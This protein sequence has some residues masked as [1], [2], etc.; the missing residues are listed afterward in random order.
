MFMYRTLPKKIPVCLIGCWLLCL[1]SAQAQQVRTVS[2]YVKDAETGED[3][4][5]ASLYVPALKQGVSTNAYG[6]FSLTL[7]ADSA[8]LLITYVG[9]QPAQRRLLLTQN[10]QITVKLTPEK[11]ELAEVVVRAE[12]LREKLNATQMSVEKLSIREIKLVP[13]L[14]GEVDLIKV[15]QLK[16]GVQSGGEGATGLYVRG[17]GADQ[18]LVLLD[19]ATVYN[20]SHLFGFFSIFNPDAVKGV[21]LYK[22]DFPARY[23]GRLSSVVDVKLKDG[24]DQQFSGSGGVGIIA[25]R[26][27]LE[28][29]L[30]KGKASYMLSG[31]RTY[32]DIFTRQI[33][34]AN[35]GKPDYD[36]IPDY[37]FYDLNA[38]VNL[39][40][41]K[42]DR[43][44]VSGYSG[45]DVFGYQDQGAFSF[46][47][48][49]GNSTVTTRWN[50]VFTPKLF[51]NTSVIFSDYRYTIQNQFD[52]I[53][54]SLGSSIKDYSVKTD[55]DYVASSRHTIRFGAQY[56][57]HH[58]NIGRLQADSEDGRIDYTSGNQLYGSEA[59][60]YV[61]SDWAPDRRW[62]INSG[63]RL[64]G[65]ENQ[66]KWFT[67][68]EPRLAARYKISGNASVKA[69]V[70]R[71]YQY[72][73][74]VAN[75]GASLPTDIWYP[76]TRSVNPQ[77]SDQVTGGVS[78]LLF[79]GKFLLSNELYYKWL[80]NQIDFRDGA[81]L[82]INPDIE[83]EFVFGKGWSYGNEIYLEKKEG[84]TTGWMGY[85]LS[86]TWRQFDAINEGRK[87]FP[88]YDR[89]HDVTAVVI[90]ELNKRV[91][92]TL[93]WVYGTGS[94]IS[95]PVGRFILQNIPGD[96]VQIV[97]EY[98][99]R[100]S[101]R[102]ADYHRLDLGLV[103]RFKPR[104][105]ESDLTFSIYN[106]YNRRNPYFIYFE[107]VRDT[108]TD[109]ITSFKAKQVSLFPVIPSVTYNFKF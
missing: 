75:S 22:G 70:A 42:R 37:Y 48:K 36:P 90:H 2:G 27:T 88:R 28:G 85:T 24:N 43:L 79:G 103:W 35:A 62:R 55:L 98:T 6:Y 49:W 16:P 68:A 47:F 64:S 69:S 67:G 107:E 58:F 108:Q 19:E 1:L 99:S 57:Y 78:V 32:F 83:R 31:R 59:C 8:V 4:I 20:A 104:W 56:T 12:S 86:W 11:Q 3:L 23:G 51:A 73:H 84:R 92:F 74:L 38:K 41:G 30:D 66:G 45:R 15:L 7:P 14:F 21:D 102:M 60:A 91:S 5:G 87:F 54:F 89:R 26:L 46:D 10:Q 34:R 44:F 65:F 81:Q 29:P 63:L 33:N 93:T 80:R 77:R 40:I 39:D 76:S 96:N 18:N 50:H 97:P 109:I 106:A 101:F 94:A 71:M 61:S 52:G 9:Y 82:F 13:A 105:G 25:S 53:R 95:L 72:V 17:G 100:N